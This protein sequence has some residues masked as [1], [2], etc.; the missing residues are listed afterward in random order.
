MRFSGV[1]NTHARNVAEVVVRCRYVMTGRFGRLAMLSMSLT[2][3]AGDSSRLKV[4]FR[5][6]LPIE[7]SKLCSELKLFYIFI[8]TSMQLALGSFEH[9]LIRE[10]GAAN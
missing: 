8:D 7:V 10:D 9:L 1:G 6:A 2:I 4:I 3:E 5:S